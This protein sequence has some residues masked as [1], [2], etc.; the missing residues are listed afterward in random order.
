MD[1]LSPTAP[2]SAGSARAGTPLPPRS[3]SAAG[4]AVICDVMEAAAVLAAGD[5]EPRPGH[6]HGKAGQG[7]PTGL[8]KGVLDV[9]TND[10]FNQPSGPEIGLD[11]GLVREP[12]DSPAGISDELLESLY[13]DRDRIALDLNNTLVHQMFAVSL[14]LHAALSRIEH[15][16]GD[17]QAAE[18]IRQAIDGLDQAIHDLRNTV[19]DR[20]NRRGP[21][22][23]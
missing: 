13:K 19:I 22:P 20:G 9:T 18:K 2:R 10:D 17:G 5:I 7:L 15:D 3:D 11:A 1:D 12:A 8:R 4:L 6:H 14:D 21:K 23:P 16:T